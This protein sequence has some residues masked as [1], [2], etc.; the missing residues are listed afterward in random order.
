[1]NSSAATH[2]EVEILIIGGG[3][4]GLTAARELRD[5]GLQV[6]VLDKGRGFG[7]RM[8]GRTFGGAT[9]EHGAHFLEA[10]TSR[11]AEEIAQWCRAKV[12]EKWYQPLGE[13]DCAPFRFRA[14]P[15]ISSL[16]RYLASGTELLRAHKV[17]SLG[18]EQN[19]WVAVLEDGGQV[20]AAAV[21]LTCPVPQS[22]DLLDHG[23]VSLAQDIRHQLE[24]ITYERCLTVMA[25]LDGPSL[26]TSPGILTPASG[27]IARL[28]D[29][30][31]QGASAVPA[32]TIQARHDFSLASWDRPRDEV[33]SELLAAAQPWLD[34]KVTEYQVHGWKYCRPLRGMIASCLIGRDDPPLVFA[35][36]AFG[37][38]DLESAAHSGWASAA[39]LMRPAP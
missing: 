1:M 3:M 25:A 39:A 29:H 31:V 30:H 28:C 33:A 17:V 13:E 4:T 34:R 23:K 20:Q 21:L 10:R 6:L 7:G 27:P 8:A 19:R 26:L 15:S 24:S 2:R 38:Y 37:G 16:A 18:M 11:F 5:R 22:L 36:D 14:T 12:A 35:G 32:V 9:F